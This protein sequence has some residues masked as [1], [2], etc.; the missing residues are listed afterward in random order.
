[1]YITKLEALRPA[2]DERLA[3]RDEIHKSINSWIEKSYGIKDF[4]EITRN[5]FKLEDG[6][7]YLTLCR[8]I[9]SVRTEDLACN[10]GA[11]VLGYPILSLPFLDDTFS[12]NNHE[13]RS[14]LNFKWADYGR[15]KNLYVYGE[16]IVDGSIMDYS[17]MPLSMIKTS[18]HIPGETLPEFHFGLRAKVFGEN[19]TLIDVSNLDRI[20]VRASI[21]KPE[22][23]FSIENSLSK[24]KHISEIDI[25]DINYRPIS[26]WYYPLYLSWFL[27][28]SMVLLE[29]YDNELSQVS[30]A[31]KL[32]EHTV[33]L[34]ENGT[35]LRPLVLK[36]PPLDDKML[37]MPKHVINCPSAINDISALFL[38]RN[39][40]DSVSFF[41]DIADAVIGW[42]S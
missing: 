1:M 8:Q 40:G 26:E 14:Y 16:R 5:Y 11:G 4:I 33:D 20:Y 24:K 41:S 38:K 21:N 34:I 37:Y 17:G 30:E 28:G 22:Y 19:D 7:T 31:K 2:I 29:T 12:P 23:V 6:K 32:F 36:V 39:T 13:K 9:P 25:E 15:K 3:R 10:I 42:H 27:D 35:G 18:S